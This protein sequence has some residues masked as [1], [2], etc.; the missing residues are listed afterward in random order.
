MQPII[1][2]VLTLPNALGPE[3]LRRG[4]ITDPDLR[5]WFELLPE[6]VASLPPITKTKAVPA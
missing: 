4:A 1:S 2:N 6:V 5:H 3:L